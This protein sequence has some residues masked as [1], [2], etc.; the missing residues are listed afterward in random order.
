MA[1]TIGMLVD[2]VR[3]AEAIDTVLTDKK[4]AEFPPEDLANLDTV[5][6]AFADLGKTIKA[7][8]VGL[9]VPEYEDDGDFVNLDSHDLDAD[10]NGDLLGD[11]PV[12]RR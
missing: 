10:G 11:V 1:L 9:V 2:V 6:R 8:E 3:F 5:L 4:L 12:R 7:S